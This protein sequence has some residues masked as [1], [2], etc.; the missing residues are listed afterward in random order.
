MYMMCLQHL[1]SISKLNTCSSDPCSSGT[2]IF[3]KVVCNLRLYQ[4]TQMNFFQESSISWALLSDF[5]VTH[6]H[7]I[8]CYKKFRPYYQLNMSKGRIPSLSFF[9]FL[10]SRLFKGIFHQK[11]TYYFGTN[12]NCFNSISYKLYIFF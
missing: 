1:Y 5:E 8:Y 7:G 6:K 3:L 2:L 11:T 4:K 9:E 10:F 12:S